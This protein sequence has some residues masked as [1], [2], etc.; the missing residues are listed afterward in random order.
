MSNVPATITTSNVSPRERLEALALRIRSLYILAHRDYTERRTKV[1]SNYGSGPLPK[2]DGGIDSSGRRYHRPIWEE[3]ACF[4]LDH[5]VDPEIL[6]FST[7][8]KFMNDG[9][10]QPPLPPYLSGPEALIRINKHR[11]LY[12]QKVAD[13]LNMQNDTMR[14]QYN[15]LVASGFDERTS[16]RAVLSDRSYE[17]SALYRY[18]M[19]FRGDQHDLADSFYEAAFTQ[20][21]YKQVLYDVL[22]GDLIPPPMKR[23]GDA[24]RADFVGRQK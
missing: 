20:Y 2:W 17:L 3:L 6:V 13:A 23:E 18:C 8:D 12:R 19:A 21:L 16:F 10:P 5:E 9:S 15:L 11:D 22:W 7:F 24:F 4:A 14:V 1:K